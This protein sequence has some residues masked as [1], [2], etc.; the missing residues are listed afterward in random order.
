MFKM[1]IKS[2]KS[3]W[4]QERCAEIVI[5]HVDQVS[6]SAVSEHY[7]RAT[8]EHSEHTY[9]ASCLFSKLT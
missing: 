6:V 7:K 9:F 5:T 1:K 4:L 8:S 2:M 3:Y